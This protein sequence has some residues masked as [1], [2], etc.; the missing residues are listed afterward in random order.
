MHGN[1]DAMVTPAY[2]GLVTFPSTKVGEVRHGLQVCA[3]V[4]N[5]IK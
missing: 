3:M 1:K 4:S 5:A 2:S